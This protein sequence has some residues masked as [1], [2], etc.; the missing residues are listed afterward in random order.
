MSLAVESPSLK[1][2]QLS[3]AAQA[4]FNLGISAAT[5]KAY[6]AGLQKYSTFCKE[7]HLQPIPAQEDTLQLFVTHLA[8]QRLSYE[9]IKVYLAAV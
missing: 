2:S 1:I 6:T 5:K 3:A 8:Q 7:F 4:Y 9:T